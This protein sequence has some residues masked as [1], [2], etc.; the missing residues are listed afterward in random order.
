MKEPEKDMTAFLPGMLIHITFH[1]PHRIM[2]VKHKATVSFQRNQHLISEILSES[3]VPD[4]R[5]AV[6]TARMQVQSLMAHQQKL[7]ARLFQIEEQ[8][9][10][11]KRKFLESTDSF[12]NEHKSLCNLKVDVDMEK[13]CP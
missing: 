5:S 8:H 2:S 12:N 9:Q 4:I 11:K 7:E 1:N 6:T 3:A 13:N 10:E